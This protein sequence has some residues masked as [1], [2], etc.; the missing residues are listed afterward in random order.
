MVLLSLPSTYV[1]LLGSST[2]LVYLFVSYVLSYRKLCQ[3]KGPFLA[4]L[5]QY[6]LSRATLR[7]QVSS[8]GADVLKNNGEAMQCTRY[9]YIWCAYNYKGSPARI[10]P[11]QL[12]T[13]DPA[14][15]RAINAPRSTLHA[16]DG[17]T[18]C[19]ST[20]S[21]ITYSLTRGE[22]AHNYFRSKIIHDVR[23]SS[24]KFQPP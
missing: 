19:D 6:W 3:F 12:L 17:T 20:Q 5:S 1:A 14:L 23:C 9:S 7:S 24:V 22:E 2:A 16:V 10:G 21:R 4:S 11:N 8:A 15:I 18:A 13:D